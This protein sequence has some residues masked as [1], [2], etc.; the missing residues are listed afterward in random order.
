LRRIE[1]L[2]TPGMGKSTLADLLARTR[3][4]T[5]P[6]WMEAE[7]RPHIAPRGDIEPALLAAYDALTS[8]IEQRAGQLLA[9]KAG[10]AGHTVQGHWES[11]LCEGR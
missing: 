10:A 7:A 2:G 3:T 1:I 4:R 8:A 6:W 9:E 11:I 5:S